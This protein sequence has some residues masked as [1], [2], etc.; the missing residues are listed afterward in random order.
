[1]QIAKSS[2]KPA[3]SEFPL[4]DSENFTGEGITDNATP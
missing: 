2:E 1:V 3:F 4:T